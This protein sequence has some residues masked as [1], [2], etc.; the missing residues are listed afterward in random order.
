MS[1]CTLA[2]REWLGVGGLTLL[3]LGLRLWNLWDI[4]SPTDELLGVGLGLATARGEALPLTDFEPYIGAL[5]TYLLASLFLLLGPSPFVGRLIPCLAGTLTVPG[6]LSPWPRGGGSCR[7]R[8][9]G[10]AP[11]HL[12][13][14]CTGHQPPSVVPRAYA[15]A[16]DPGS[17]AVSSRPGARRRA[18]S[19]LGWILAG[20]GST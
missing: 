11:R 1:T 9:R 15:A 5:W 10:D 14:P 20:A 2:T 8:H 7:G 3:G 16:G 19:G 17:L 6:D 18:R 12:V 4:P 13:S